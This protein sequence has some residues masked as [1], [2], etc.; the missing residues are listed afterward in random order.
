MALSIPIISEFNDKGIKRA[1]AEF[2]QLETAGEKAQFAIK[3]AAIPAG[4]AV[5]ALGGI[6]V[7]AAKGAEEARQANQRLSNVLESMGFDE[8]TDRVSAYAES[9]ERTIAV[10]ADVIKATQTKLATFANLTKTVNEA[11]GAFDR[12][13]VAALDLAAAGFGTAETNAIQLGKALEDPIKGIAALA[14]SGVTFTE[15]EKEKIRT[16]VE[17]NQVLEAQNLILSAIEKQVGGTAEASASS[18]DKIKFSLAGISDTLGEMVLPLVDKFAVAMQGVAV[19]VSENE[20]LVG[21][22][23]IAFGGLAV[24]VLAVNAA[25]KV[26]NAMLIIVKGAQ[27]LLNLAMAANPIGLIVVGIAALIA[28][29]AVAYKKFEGFRNGVNSI[30]NGLIAG[31]ENWANTFIK[32]INIIIRGMNLINP[33]TDINYIQEINLGRLGGGGSSSSGD[34]GGAAREGGTG[35]SFDT[36]A[37]FMPPLALP[38]GGGGGGGGGSSRAAT[39]ADLSKNYAG[40]MGGN[41]G[42]TGNA[43]DFSSL[44]DQFMVERGTPITVNVT[45]GLATSADIGRAVVNSIKAM[46]RVDGAAQIQV[47]KWLPR[48]SNQGLMTYRSPQGSL[49]TRSPLTTQ[50]RVCSITPSMCWTARQSL[51]P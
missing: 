48:S 26:Y 21:G 16:L 23:V 51:H 40:N 22:L 15:Q 37:P 35:A 14:K 29:L 46:N 30:L 18:F 10:D 43:G 1:V 34:R 28:A 11:G 47:G 32:A 36:S 33:F 38:S 45:G 31:F 25:M 41:Q 6:L 17:S 3:K 39:L 5:A 4:I 2:K 19:F 9:L 50:R 12:A 49:W 24:A 42:I 20:K 7:K 8:A 27:I 13:T 44:F